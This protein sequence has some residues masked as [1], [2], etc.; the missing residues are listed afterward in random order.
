MTTY[1]T[2]DLFTEI[3]EGTPIPP[4]KLEYFRTRF[5][6]QVYNLVA[7]AFDQQETLTQAEYARRIH[8]KREVMNRLLN[9]PSNSTLD[10]V[11]DLL[12][13]LKLLPILESERIVDRL[14]PT[15]EQQTSRLIEALPGKQEESPSK[16]QPVTMPSLG[17]AINAKQRS[18]NTALM[19][20]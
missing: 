5:K 2:R 8:R 16:Q 20:S 4:E 11:C 18:G 10:T 19:P 3:L 13:G 17:G 14:M 12:I 15:R 7:S 6:L 9:S 1:Q